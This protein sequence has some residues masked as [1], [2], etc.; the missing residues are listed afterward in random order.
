MS[1]FGDFMKPSPGTEHALALVGKM[2]MAWNRLELTWFLI[3]TCLVYQLPRETAEAI[4][5]RH[6][7]GNGQRELIMTIARVALRPHPEILTFLESASKETN[8]I[9]TERNDI[10]HGDY[11]FS[12]QD[13]FAFLSEYRTP[14]VNLARLEIGPGGERT[15]FRNIFAGEKDLDSALANLT[16][17]IESI[18]KQ[19]DEARHHLVWT[20]LPPALRPQPLPDTMPADMRAT[21]LQGHPEREPPKT[22]LKWTPVRPAARQR[23]PPPPA[24]SPG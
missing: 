20:F 3:Y 18:D 23:T 21:L 2:V 22:T 9:A 7:T 11:I 12:W 5:K 14:N 24:P 15:K 6:T 13:V 8:N 4:F 19:L 17:D 10:I 16:A 1:D